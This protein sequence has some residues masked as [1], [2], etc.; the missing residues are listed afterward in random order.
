MIFKKITLFKWLIL[1]IILFV[2]LTV[3]QVEGIILCFP[4]FI[5]LRFY[6]NHKRLS[7]KRYTIVDY[8]VRMNN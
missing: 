5:I 2:R 8:K 3:V 4:T 1:P 7:G 6:E